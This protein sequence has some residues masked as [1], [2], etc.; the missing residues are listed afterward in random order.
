MNKCLKFLL[1]SY[2]LVH[3]G[4]TDPDSSSLSP[5]KREYQRKLAEKL[6]GS[7][8]PDRKRLLAFAASNRTKNN[9]R[10]ALKVLYERTATHLKRLNRQIPK[11][12]VS[13][14]TLSFFNEEQIVGA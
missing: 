3:G 7:E 12:L 2:Q 8:T 10:A 9:E 14:L 6:T 4:L 1:N 11:V 13:N 5:S